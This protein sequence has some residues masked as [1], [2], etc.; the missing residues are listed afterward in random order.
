MRSL[1]RLNIYYRLLIL[2]LST[3]GLFFVLYLCL[4]FYTLR[5]EKNVYRTA[6]KEYKNEINSIFLLNSKLHISTNNYVSFWDELVDFTKTRDRKWYNEAI[7]SEFEAYE[8]D[9]LG[10][11]TLNEEL[12]G[13]TTN[14]KIKSIN[15]MPKEAFKKLHK[16][17]LIRFHL[18]TADGVIEVFGSTI[19]PTADPQRNKFKPSGYFFTARLID[20]QF[21]KNLEFISTSLV[22]LQQKSVEILNDSNTLTVLIPLK[23]WQN[24]TFANLVFER[25]FSLNFD[26]TKK[27]LFIIIIATVVNLFI[28]LYYYRR[29]VYKPLNLITH[30]LETKD[31]K[32]MSGLKKLD[33]EFGH[34]GNLFEENNNQRKQLEIAKQKAEESDKLKSSFLANLSH[35]IR[36]PMNAII[37]FSDLLIEQNLNQDEKTNYLKIISNSG[38]NLILI[39]EDLIEMSKIDSKQIT[40]NYKPVD[41]DNC[42]LELYNTIKVTIPDQKEIDF[43]VF[44]THEKLK[45]KILTDET[46]LK[47]I[48]TNLVTNAIKFTVK[49]SVTIGYEIDERA[50]IIEIWV[51]DTGLGIDQDN[52]N[53]IFDRFRRI[54]DDYSIKLS[55][56]GLGLSITKAYVELLGGKIAVTS[57]LGIGSKFSLTIPLKYDETTFYLDTVKKEHKSNLA[58]QETIL[59]AEDDDINFMLLER[60]LKFKNYHI[61]RAVNGQQA[62]DICRTNNEIDLIF[63]DIK[64][65]IMGGLEAFKLIRDFNQDIPIVAN[66]AYSAQE[67]REKILNDGFTNYISKPINKTILFNMLDEIFSRN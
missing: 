49:G 47:Q 19:H 27:I 31:E 11:Y 8:S 32:S 30:I 4:Y 39:I 48:L 3:S 28:Y 40:P 12:I 17:K 37:G 44:K 62:V 43:A 38:K 21:T 33:G 66:T 46:K 55:G 25:S 1:S 51:E 65:P 63:M 22:Q 56:L 64:M 9:F 15:F 61:L 57:S 29:W 52:I 5:E 50:K 23:N 42:I 14:K 24:T 53:I 16:E 26:N 20:Q 45:I 18:Q 58:K 34:I 6:L 2:I 35:E 59:I 13:Y 10:I 36:T 54:E 60:I 41:L 7:S 67:D